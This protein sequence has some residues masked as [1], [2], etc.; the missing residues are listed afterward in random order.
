MVHPE[1]GT[2]ILQQP[3]GLQKK[4]T[5][6]SSMQH[7]WCLLVDSI[8][9]CMTPAC[10]QFSACR[11]GCRNQHKSCWPV[12]LAVNV[13]FLLH[14]YAPARPTHTHTKCGCLKSDL[15]AQQAAAS[16]TPHPPV[17]GMQ[18]H[19]PQV[20]TTLLSAASTHWL[21]WRTC[22]PRYAC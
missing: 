10:H 12:P 15:H 4:H 1:S 14:L 6:R 3:V 18:L 11:C 19:A 13:S 16:S 21:G 8:D 5:I 17:T 2:N 22:Q 20:V 7:H 9:L